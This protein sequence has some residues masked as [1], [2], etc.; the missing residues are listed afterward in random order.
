M[1]FLIGTNTL[2]Q[3]FEFCRG[4]GLRLALSP[5]LPALTLTPSDTL[6]PIFLN[7]LPISL[8]SLGQAANTNKNFKA[9]G[10]PW[11]LVH[12]T[13]LGRNSFPKRSSLSL[14]NWPR[15]YYPSLSVL[16][17]F[18][19]HSLPSPLPQGFPESALLQRGRLLRQNHVR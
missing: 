11:L 12:H 8:H 3:Y 19:F 4:V 5:R 17:S 14:A 18:F 15:S 1:Y 6:A 13:K 10:I 7:V 9:A 16:L 2:P